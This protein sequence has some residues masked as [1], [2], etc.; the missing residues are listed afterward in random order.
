MEI[1]HTLHAGVKAN[2]N[3]SMFEKIYLEKSTQ[4]GANSESK[5]TVLGDVPKTAASRMAGRAN[6]ANQAALG[7]F[8]MI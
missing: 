3:G 2:D 5:S 7:R 6:R 8:I 1:I 4:H